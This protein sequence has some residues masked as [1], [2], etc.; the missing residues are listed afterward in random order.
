MN[1]IEYQA[2]HLLH[3]FRSHR[4]RRRALK[5][6][7]LRFIPTEELEAAY[8]E[9]AFSGRLSYPASSVTEDQARLQSCLCSAAQLNSAAFRYWAQALRLPWRYHR[10]L[11]EFCFICQ[12]LFERGMLENGRKGL[13]FAVGE[14]PLPA[15]FASRGCSIVATDLEATDQ[16]AQVWADTAQLAVSVEKLERAAICEPSLFRERVIFRAV[17]MNQIPGDLTDFDFTWSSCSFEHCGSIQLGLDF[18][19]NQMQCLRPGGVAVHTTEFNLNSNDDTLSEG[20]TV[21]FRKRDIDSLVHRLKQ[22]G[23]HVEPIAYALGSSRADRHIDTFPYAEAP[24]LKL[25]LAER[26]V[27]T[28]IALI[29]RKSE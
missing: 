15:L 25:V 9:P 2:R 26:F 23:H 8:E 3:K 4:D 16:R 10:K 20:S 11:W 22:D 14:E 21:I 7:L 19:V 1:A 29:V 17:D 24:H 13:G 18:V 5:A 28:S 12:A 27:S 6:P